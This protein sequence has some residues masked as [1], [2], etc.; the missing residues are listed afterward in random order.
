MT[1]HPDGFSFAG[2][3]VKQMIALSTGVIALTVTFASDVFG[4]VSGTPEAVLVTAWSVY[5][6]SILF[7]LWTLLALTGTLGANATT[8]SIYNTNIRLPA[9]GQVI[10]FFLASILI[11]AFGA[12]ALSTSV[13][14]HHI[15]R[16]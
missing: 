8:A 2:D 9:I 12:L 3:T 14:H 1:D 6:L 16:F 13:P 10:T 5:L 7:G 11:V 15:I 4:D